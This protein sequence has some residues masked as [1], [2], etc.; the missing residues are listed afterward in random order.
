MSLNKE[1][2]TVMDN[3]IDDSDDDL[4]AALSDIE[5]LKN[6]SLCNIQC[7]IVKGHDGQV[8]IRYI[9]FV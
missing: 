7:N 6:T 8:R 3:R 1:N 4:F 2:V 5:Y 9:K